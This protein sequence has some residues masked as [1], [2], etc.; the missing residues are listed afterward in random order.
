M[1]D[2]L[3]TARSTIG[4][5]ATGIRDEFCTDKSTRVSD[6][7]MPRVKRNKAHKVI[8]EGFCFLIISSYIC[9]C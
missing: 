8:E 9:G 1:A 5:D 4:E 6:S 7:D 2:D 3:Q